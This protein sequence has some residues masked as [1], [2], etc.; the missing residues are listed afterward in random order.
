MKA[1]N[2]Y[3]QTGEERITPVMN[4]TF[5]CRKNASK[6]PVT[7]SR[8]ELVPPVVRARAWRSGRGSTGPG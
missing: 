4:D 7:Y 5:G 1:Q 2:W 8:H 3:S 6:M